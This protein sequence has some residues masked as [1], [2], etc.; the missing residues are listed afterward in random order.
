MPGKTD[1]RKRK[2]APRQGVAKRNVPSRSDSRT[3]YAQVLEVVGTQDEIPELL[4]SLAGKIRLAS[5]NWRNDT[6][7]ELANYDWERLHAPKN[8]NTLYDKR[9][10]RETLTSGK[11]VEMVV[12]ALDIRKSTLL[13][14]EAVDP[15]KFA[16]TLNDFVSSSKQLIRENQGWFDK[17]TG[18]GLLAYWVYDGGHWEEASDRAL[19]VAAGVRAR[20][21][22]VVM[23]QFRTNS[24]SFP[25][26]VGISCG[27]DAGPAI[28]GFV[29]GALTIIG[30]PV[31]G[32]VRMVSCAQPFEVISNVYL[33]EALYR[34]PKRLSAQNRATIRRDYRETK[35]YARQ[36]VYLLDLQVE[37]NAMAIAAWHPRWFS[38][39]KNA[40]Q[41]ISS[42]KKVPRK[43]SS[44]ASQRRPLQKKP[45]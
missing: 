20:F 39:T 44:S 21:H 37:P 7:K 3:K 40:R 35:E 29:A 27:I 26:G 6:R 38:G 10:L 23:D 24:K 43:G 31:V 14:K 11:A 2:R 1:A 5:Q 17:F 19:K 36:E 12:L 41:G 34:D 22:N 13:M 25:D 15:K 30:S 4:T 18:D 9:A 16:A 33:G 45:K 28:M 32:A 42:A 8:V